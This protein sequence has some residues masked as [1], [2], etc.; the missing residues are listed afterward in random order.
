MDSIM[1]YL[2]QGATTLTDLITLGGPVVAILLAMSV[3]A[4]TIVLVKLWQ[5]SRMRIRD[6]RTARSALNI[7]QGG[8]VEAAISTAHRS[9]NPTAQVLACA[10]ENKTRNL[11]EGV[12]REEL[13]RIGGDLLESMRAWLRPLEVIAS[14]APLLGLFGTVLGMIDAFQSLQQAGSQVDP[15]LLAGG[16]WEALLTTAVGLAVAMP[17]IA[18]LNWFERSIDRLAHDMDS[19]VTQVF[20]ADIV[21]P[22]APTQDVPAPE[23]RRTPYI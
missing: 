20:T 11:P 7:Y 3:L 22:N 1:H 16:I 10:I 13:L 19:I 4:L 18:I 12:I 15:A 5:F 17:V 9:R 8:N 23:Q 6:R 2:R 21:R 14:L